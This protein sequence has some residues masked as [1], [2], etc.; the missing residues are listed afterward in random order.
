[1]LEFAFNELKVHRIQAL[2]NDENINS[3]KVMIKIGMI[4]EG[5][6]RGVRVLNNR[7][8]GSHIYSLLE[9]EFRN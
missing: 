5:T 9:N 1:M 8:Y 7:W 2:C 3:E 4:K 6:C